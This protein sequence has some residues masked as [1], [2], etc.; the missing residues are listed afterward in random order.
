MKCNE[1]FFCFEEGQSAVMHIYITEYFQRWL[2]VSVWEGFITTSPGISPK[3]FTFLG[4]AF[5][6]RPGQRQRKFILQIKA[7]RKKNSNFEWHWRD[8]ITR[9]EYMF[10]YLCLTAVRIMQHAS[11]SNRFSGQKYS[12]NPQSIDVHV[13]TQVNKTIVD[14]GQRYSIEVIATAKLSQMLA[15]TFH[16]KNKKVK[17]AVKIHPYQQARGNHSNHF[18]FS[19]PTF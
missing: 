18:S 12:F 3:S 19:T 16:R 4:H 11:F 15:E 9:L 5:N 1:P 2:S 10:C 8:N 6:P 13:N 14:P 7:G 17:Y